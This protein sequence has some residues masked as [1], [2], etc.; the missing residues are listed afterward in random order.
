[1]VA[2]E[3]VVWGSLFLLAFSYVIY[4]LLLWL[5]AKGKS[6]NTNCFD[7]EDQWPNV[8]VFMPAYNEEAVLA[9]KLASLKASKYPGEVFYFF[10]SDNSSDATSTI[11]Q[12]AAHEFS[13][14]HF[15]DFASRQGKPNQVNHLVQLASTMP[16]FEEGIFLLT[17]ASVMLAPDCI[18]Q[19]VQHFK[20]PA[21]FLVDASMRSMGLN[22][23]DISQSEGIYIKIEGLLKSWESRAFGKMMGPFGGCYA[24][25]ASYYS[26][27]PH[28]F[29]VDDFYITMKGFQK[30][31][32]AINEPKAVCYEKV[33]TEQKEEFRRKRRISAGNFQNLVHFFGSWF[34]PRNAVSFA[35]FSH[36]ILRWCGP[37]FII[38]ATIGSAWMWWN[39]ST[40]PYAILL[41]LLL[42]WIVLI[43]LVDEILRSLNIH[44]SPLRNVTYFN[45]MNWA[46]LMGFFK[47]L[48]GIKSN[49]W[50][51]P[52]RN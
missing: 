18:Q 6:L 9:D 20:N 7:A 50:Q 35:F 17:D 43:P 48:Y 15:V 3:I 24:L 28:N 22:A 34:P 32:L 30:G 37:F 26:P 2:I 42:C 10:S 4:P 16:G 51:P 12:D 19:L 45:A 41:V 23:A 39:G 31:G 47:Y 46:L 44:L 49:V 1:M 5:L 13:N 36:K 11:F 27:V 38:F 52:K 29:L 40:F 14:F 33:G 25:R 21:V 8:F